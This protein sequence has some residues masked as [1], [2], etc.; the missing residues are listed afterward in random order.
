MVMMIM[1]ITAM[2]MKI[3]I[4]MSMM[5]DGTVGAAGAVD[6]SV[7]KPPFFPKPSFQHP[8]YWHLHMPR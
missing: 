7:M 6:H 4:M 8:L 3:S 2:T 5:M 1:M